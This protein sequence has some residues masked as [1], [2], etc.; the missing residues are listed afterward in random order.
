[1]WGIHTLMNNWDGKE[2]NLILK[3][4][5]MPL[6]LG[7]LCSIREKVYLNETQVHT[8][9]RLVLQVVARCQRLFYRLSKTAVENCNKMSQF[10]VSTVIKSCHK[11]SGADPGRRNRMIC[12]PPPKNVLNFYFSYQ[13]T[14]ATFFNTIWCHFGAKSR[15]E[16]NLSKKENSK[17]SFKILLVPLLEKKQQ[18]KTKLD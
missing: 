2:C 3:N 6:R 17:D 13:L 15:E 14:K 9:Y 4:N 18:Q 1:M 5:H 8:K 10:V 12:P 11:R 7:F 16:F